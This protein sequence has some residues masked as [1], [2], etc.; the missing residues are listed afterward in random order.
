M[1]LAVTVRYDPANNVYSALT[2]C[3][4]TETNPYVIGI[5]YASTD[6]TEVLSSIVEQARE[7]APETQLSFVLDTSAQNALYSSSQSHSAA[8]TPTSLVTAQ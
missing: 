8:P 6:L 3:P 5:S 4:A 1:V 2:D 7:F